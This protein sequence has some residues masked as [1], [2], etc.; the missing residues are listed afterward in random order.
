MMSA[1]AAQAAATIATTPDASYTYSK[2]GLLLSGVTAVTLPDIEVTFGNN[3]TNNDDIFITLNG[4]V[5]KALTVTPASIVCSIAGNA[6]GYVTTVNNGWNFRVTAVGGVSID[7]TCTFSGLEV[8]GASLAGTNG[9]LCY[10]ANRA[11]TAQVVDKACSKEVILVESQFALTTDQKLNGKINVYDER[12]SFVDE[13][14]VAPGGGFEEDT[15]NFTTT[16]TNGFPDLT[17]F[18]GP[19]VD[20]DEVVA[21]IDGDFAWVDSKK[22]GGDEDGK[23]EAG[24]FDFAID[25]AS[26][27]ADASS[28]CTQLVWNGTPGDT[29]HEGYFEVPGDV[30]LNPVDWVGNIEWT[31]SLGS[32]TGKTGQA[33]DPGVWGINGAQVYIQYMPYGTG[34]GRI[35]YAAHTGKIAAEVTADIYYNG[36]VT[37]CD[38]GTVAGESVTQLSAVVDTCALAALGSAT[39]GKVAI[40][41]TFTAP[42]KD[43]EV[44]S[45]YNVN[46]DDRGTV[47]N[48]SNGRT[49]FYG[50]GF[51]FVPPGP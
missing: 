26:F 51:P 10:Q 15:L 43:I 5:S 34:I 39:S 4:V 33:W 47:V 7:D 27:T 18:T 40:L 24:E 9:D 31:Y 13:E 49:F 25:Y 11:V 6:V 32:K 42:D 8:E 23:C 41:L 2:E 19:T 46:G 3:L 50:T 45:A 1:G 44:Y 21:T 36:D 28:T 30:V 17:G 37:Q 16:E 48:T 20:T 38:L 14:L 35:I 22:L 29:D 12:L